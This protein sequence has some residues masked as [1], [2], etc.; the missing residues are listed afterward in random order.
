MDNPKE[1]N[2]LR[3]IIIWIIGSIIALYIVVPG[4]LVWPV[5]KVYQGKSEI[6]RW[7]EVPMY[8]VLFPHVMVAKVSPYYSKWLGIQGKWLGL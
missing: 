5:F 3:P 8:V 7:V 2:V 4:A 1:S 6:P